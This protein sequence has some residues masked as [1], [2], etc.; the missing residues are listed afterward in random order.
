MRVAFG[1]RYNHKN[2]PISSQRSGE[3]T[4]EGYH[5]SERHSD[6]MT[7]RWLGNKAKPT[8]KDDEEWGRMKK[9]TISYFKQLIDHSIFHH[10]TPVMNAH[11]LWKKLEA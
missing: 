2:L 1:V 8:C 6:G 4:G 5:K 10:I 7:F 9:R 3:A 11:G